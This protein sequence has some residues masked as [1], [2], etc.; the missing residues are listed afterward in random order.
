MLK[1]TIFVSSFKLYQGASPWLLIKRYRLTTENRAIS[2]VT[3]VT[4][5]E[6][7]EQQV[8]ILATIEDYLYFSVKDGVTLPPQHATIVI[9]D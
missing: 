9:E 4:S 7:P 5:F 6:N 8:V 1:N 3:P 2:L